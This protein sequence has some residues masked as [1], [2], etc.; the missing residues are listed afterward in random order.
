MFI[1]DRFFSIVVVR[2]TALRP[3]PQIL[4]RHHAFY[5][6]TAAVYKGP[7]KLLFI[8]RHLRNFRLASPQLPSF[9]VNNYF[10]RRNYHQFGPFFLR[11]FR[12][13]FL[14]PSRVFSSV[15]LSFY[16]P[17]CHRT[18]AVFVFVAFSALL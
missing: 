3:T 15:T 4:R 11:R 2:P 10:S 8:V 7:T 5:A 17:P 12:A 9:A 16:F 18:P 14:P 6:S 1:L 13:I